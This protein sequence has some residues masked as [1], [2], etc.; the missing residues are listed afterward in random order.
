MQERI[1]SILSVK[2]ML[3]LYFM[4]KNIKILAQ[5]TM[6]IYTFVHSIN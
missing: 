1:F 2:S 5:L 4:L 3:F 6:R